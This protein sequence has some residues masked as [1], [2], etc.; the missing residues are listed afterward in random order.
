MLM[1][2]EE[3]IANRPKVYSLVAQV[4]ENGKPIIS[5]KTGNSVYLLTLERSD[6]EARF[7]TCYIDS[8]ELKQL[9]SKGIEAQE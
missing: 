6:R 7:D 9:V 3:V 1:L 2:L 5:A 8:E 4:D